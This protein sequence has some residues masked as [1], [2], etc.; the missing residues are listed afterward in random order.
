MMTTL[1]ET[2]I[3]QVKKNGV[4]VLPGM[5]RLARCVARVPSCT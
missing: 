1:A 3:S 5:G 4:F 2:T